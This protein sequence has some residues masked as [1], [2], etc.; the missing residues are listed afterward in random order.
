M[1]IVLKMH[2]FDFHL[3]D[4]F[5]GLHSGWAEFF[6]LIKSFLSD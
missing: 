6:S 2:P 4:A 3:F 1:L 5:D